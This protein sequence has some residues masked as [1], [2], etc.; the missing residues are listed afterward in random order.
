LA[1]GKE[2]AVTRILAGLPNILKKEIG[3]AAHDMLL[4]CRY[5]GIICNITK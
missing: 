3:F 1:F 5:N 4:Y 2:E